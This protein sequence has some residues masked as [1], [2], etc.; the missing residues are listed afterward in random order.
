MAEASPPSAPA[1][2]DTAAKLPEKVII[3]QGSKNVT[4]KAG[5]TVH[6]HYVGTLENGEL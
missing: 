6:I 4:P 2:E 3:W 5:D 1:A